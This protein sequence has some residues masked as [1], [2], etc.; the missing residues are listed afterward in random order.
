MNMINNKTSS[1]KS[2][3]TKPQTPQTLKRYKS[4]EVYLV[5]K[6]P[7]V[8]ASMPT[9][10]VNLNAPIPN[11]L[12]EKKEMKLITLESIKNAQ[13]TMTA[14]DSKP[15][16]IEKPCFAKIMNDESIQELDTEENK[17]EDSGGNAID[18]EP[19]N[20]IKCS[21]FNDQFYTN[22]IGEATSSPIKEKKLI[23]N[24]PKPFVKQNTKLPEEEQPDNIDTKHRRMLQ[25]AKKGDRDAFLE[26]VEM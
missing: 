14:S 11:R 23:N 7:N 3:T 12:S 21:Q 10:Q 9:V 5:G 6:K 26:I 19:A 25:C 15:K 4:Q 8:V 24:L 18:E 17:L 22:S 16:K 13:K 20:E 2:L 1:K